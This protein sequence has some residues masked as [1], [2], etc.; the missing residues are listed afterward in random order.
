M[1]RF[2]LSRTI[3]NKGIVPKQRRFPAPDGGR[4]EGTAAVTMTGK[5]CVRCQGLGAAPLPCWVSWMRPRSDGGKSS[6][7]LL[8]S[9]AN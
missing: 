3:Q 4:A 2:N 7:F 9:L 8:P 5:P 1:N 6:V